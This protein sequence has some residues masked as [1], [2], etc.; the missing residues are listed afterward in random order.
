SAAQAAPGVVAVLTAADLELDPQPPSGNVHGPFER[1]VLAGDTVRF[2]GDPLA[3]VIAEDLGRAQDAAEAVVVELD[4]LP[5]VVDP[6]G[7]LEPGAPLLFPE[8]GTNVVHTFA[9]QWDEDV[10]AGAEVVVRGRFVNQRLA[11]VPMET[12]GC[13]VVPD[14][15][16]S[17]T[18]WV[19]TQIPFDVRGDLAEW[20]H[21]DKRRIR[22]IAPD[23]GGGFGAKLVVSPEYLA[24]AAA[25]VRLG[26]P[27]RWT[28]TRS[29]SMVSLTHGRAQVQEVELGARRDGRVVGLRVDLVAD[30]GAYPVG[31]YLAPTTRS[32][33]SGV[34]RIPRIASRGRSVVTNTTPVSA[35]RGAGRPEATALLE[36]AMDLVAAELGM[37]P[38]EVRRRN[39]IPPDAF[40]HR[41]AVGTTYDVGD[42]GRAL[43]EALRLAGY[44]ALRA[45]QAERRARGDRRPL[46]IGVSAY[47]EV[48]AFAG[49]E[50]GGVEVHPDG[51]ATVLSGLS[52]HGQGHETSLAQIAS[53][54][55]AIP[56]ERISV[57]HS[58]TGLVPAG[59]GT[60]GSRSLQLGGTAVWNASTQ[61]LEK[62]RLLAAHLLE[63]SPADV[64]LRDDG[65]LGVAGA[66]ELA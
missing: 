17:L 56:I 24:V 44:E 42:Y 58:D 63:A 49:R 21:L 34:Y 4:P 36:R 16:G 39:L 3:L 5:V 66:P 51:T 2:V 12:N 46:G 14:P 65:R 37:D 31:A 32:M 20:L 23:V 15:D 45:E 6:V 38:V 25:A 19:S 62:A 43:D 41:T 47:V 61:V 59:D 8:A 57:V 9:A 48:T 54:L 55:L 29:E 10:L 52:P 18:V 22:V 11:P 33:L 60:Y 30:M 53:G 26:R 1:P 64:A 40:P 28:E 13:V 50:F 27:V 7:A 35:Y